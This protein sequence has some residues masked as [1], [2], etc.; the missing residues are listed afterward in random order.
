MPHYSFFYL[1]PEATPQ[2]FID[3]WFPSDQAARQ[4]AILTARD[5]DDDS[6]GFVPTKTWWHG[7]IVVKEGDREIVRIPVK[8][9]R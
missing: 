1:D 5:V 8:H 3:L 6:Q 2:P 9:E 7:A 4:E